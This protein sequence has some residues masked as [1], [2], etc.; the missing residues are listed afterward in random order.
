[1]SKK[2][3]QEVYQLRKKDYL[4]KETSTG[5]L[6]SHYTRLVDET[7]GAVIRSYRAEQEL[8]SRF[9]QAFWE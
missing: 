6:A 8:K 4:Y 2:L 9:P 5:E 3:V 1:M 7:H